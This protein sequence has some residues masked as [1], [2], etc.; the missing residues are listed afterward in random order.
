VVGATES[1]FRFV[2]PTVHLDAAQVEVVTPAGTFSPGADVI[3]HGDPG[4][5]EEYTTLELTWFDD[6]VE[7]RI[8]IYFV[9]DGVTWWADE[10]RTYDGTTDPEWFEPVATGRFFETPLGETFTG[11]V[12]L[13][14]LN[15]TGMTLQA[16]VPPAVC[17]APTAPVAVVADYPTISGL[18]MS[19]GSVGGFGASFQ[20]YD[21]AACQPLQIAD[22]RFDYTIA[23]PA[24]ATITELDRPDPAIST[25]PVGTVP[26]GGDG[27]ER[28][29]T[30]GREFDDIKSRVDITFHA[31]GTTTLR[32]TVTDAAGATVGTAEV[33]IT[34]TD[35]PADQHLASAVAPT[36]TAPPTQNLVPLPAGATFQ[37]MTPSCT[38]VDDVVYECTVPEAL[39]GVGDDLDMVGYTGILVDE[40]S[41]V[42]GGCRSVS[43]D[44]TELLCYLGQRGVDEGVVGANFLGE[45]A[46]RGFIAG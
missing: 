28:T 27:A 10:I 15:V 12:E 26:G 2:T 17:D 43:S 30:S 32:A 35:Q 20:V 37:G 9:S 40:S 36:D 11:D 14:N 6:E 24:I 3:V 39:G 8:F 22:Y 7:Q 21:T 34:V 4:M 46:P 31:A 44:A 23:D 42:S 38:P 18:S 45:W 16:F 13:P 1:A 33:P 29:A 25:S 5:P 19:G 41:H